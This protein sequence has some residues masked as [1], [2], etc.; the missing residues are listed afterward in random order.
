MAIGANVSAV[1]GG[2]ALKRLDVTVSLRLLAP[3]EPRRMTGRM[4]A[5]RDR[6]AAATSPFEGR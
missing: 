1:W 6:A 2:R 3:C 5:R 4:P